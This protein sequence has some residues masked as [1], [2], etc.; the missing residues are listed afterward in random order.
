M[1]YIN[2]GPNEDERKRDDDNNPL[3]V[4]PTVI[5]EGFDPSD[6]TNL[7]GSCGGEKND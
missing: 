7:D 2:N 4:E 6:T 5:E 1:F 3:E